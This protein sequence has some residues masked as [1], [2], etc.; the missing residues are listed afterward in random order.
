MPPSKV[1]ES[2]FT[3]IVGAPEHWSPLAITVME[4]TDEGKLT[5][6]VVVPLELN[7]R[8]WP[9]EAELSDTTDAPLGIVICSA[10]KDATSGLAAKE[11]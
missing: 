4:L 9:P 3:V 7:F 11:R 10:C 8:A 1:A 6:P 2:S 5:L